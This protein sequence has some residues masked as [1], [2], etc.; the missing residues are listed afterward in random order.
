M[1]ELTWLSTRELADL[2]ARGEVS[3]VEAVTAHLARI[4]QVNPTINAIVTLDP[5]R[6]LAQA[7]DADERQAAPPL[8]LIHI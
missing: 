5:E 7:R 2:L 4:E 6:A 1:S 8:S 3:S